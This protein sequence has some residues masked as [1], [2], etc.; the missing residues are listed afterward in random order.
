M[1]QSSTR[2]WRISAL[3]LA[4]GSEPP[5]AAAHRSVHENPIYRP[6]PVTD[7]E[8]RLTATDQE[9]VID[10]VL[11]VA[12]LGEAGLQGWW[13]SHGLDQSGRYVIGGAFPHTWR[14]AAFELAIASAKRRHEDVLGRPTALHLFSDEL[15]FRRI[16]SAWLA[17]QKTGGDGSRIDEF[18]NWTTDSA[19]VSLRAWTNV[20]SA[21]EIVGSGLLLG[22][23]TTAELDDPTTLVSVAKQLAAAY[24]D[25][26]AEFRAPYFDL[27]RD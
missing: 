26:S 23:L 17:E 13:Q 10:V 2:Q 27:A 7:A 22:R 6:M 20:D 25:Q 12:R 5:R 18:A 11:G 21:G 14:W 8:T 24:L 19:V 16:A 15:P 4:D 9:R 1:T 3:E